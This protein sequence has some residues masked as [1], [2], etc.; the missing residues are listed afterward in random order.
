MTA[1]R[2]RERA[3][4]PSPPERLPPRRGGGSSPCTY[5]VSAAGRPAAFVR[6]AGARRSLFYSARALA[7]AALLAVLCA[8]TLP[9]TAQA[10]VLVSNLGQPG[11]SSSELDDLDS[12]FLRA[13]AFSVPA[14]GGDYSLASSEI[15]IGRGIASSNF[16]SLSVSVW[17]ADSSGHP[18]S[19]LY[20]L[21]NPS[22]T[23]SANA[24]GTFRAPAD[25]TL[26]AGQTYLVVVHYAKEQANAPDWQGTESD[27]E[28]VSF[29]T[30]WTIAD[31]GLS[32]RTT[33][34]SWSDNDFAFGI[35]VN[36]T[37][38]P[39][40]APVF[41][42]TTA[43]RTVPENSTVGTA[44][45]APVTATDADTGDTLT[46]SLEGTDAASFDIDSGT[47]QIKT[48]TGVTYNYE[49]TK[50]SYSVTV[51]A[52]DGNSGTDTIT[53]TISVTDVAE[54]PSKP[55]APSLTRVTGS[56]T[57]LS[58]SWS[59]P[60][61]D[62]GPAL[63]GYE[64]QY[65]AG[66]TGT[67]SNSTSHGATVTTATI[68]GLTADTAYQVQVR[69]LN[70]ETPS[71]WSEPSAS[72]RTNALPELSVSNV[73][74]Q[75]GNALTFRVTLSPAS[76]VTVTVRAAT[77]VEGSAT[78]EASDF[79]A[80]TTT[81]TFAANEMSKQVTVTTREDSTDEDNETF[82]LT[83]SNP[84]NAALS[85]DQTTLAVF[86]V[87]EDDDDPPVLSVAPAAATEGAPVEFTVSLSAVS[88]KTVTVT[89]ATS[90]GGS[91]TAVSD[92]FTTV[93]E[94]LTFA[95][96]DRSKTVTVTTAN[97]RLDEEDEETFTLTLSGPSNAT[98][99][100][101]AST[102]VGTIRD[103]DDR[104][105]ITI[106]AATVNEGDGEIE[107]PLTL[108]RASGREVSAVWY[109]DTDGS[110]TAEPDDIVGNLSEF[111]ANRK[112]VFPPGSVSEQIRITLFDDTTDEPDE[113]FLVQLAGRVNAT[114][115]S[116]SNTVTIEDNDDPP[117][118]SIA[119]DVEQ[120]ESVA[121][122]RLTVNLSEAS[123]KE[124][125]F[126]LRR[127]DRTSDTA[128]A[129]D[130]STPGE[131][132]NFTIAA[133]A[134]SVVASRA[135]IRNDTTDEPD[136][137]FTLEIHDFRN[138]TGGTKTEA[139]VTIEDDDDPP[140]VSVAN[141]SAEEGEGAEFMVR[142]SAESGKTVT[143][144]VAT[145]GGGS[146]TA[147]SGSDYWP[148][149]SAGSSRT[150][151]PGTTELT[152]RVGLIDDTIDEPDEIFTLTLSDPSNATLS[153]TNAT[154]KGTIVDGDPAPTVTLVLTPSSIDEDG[155]TTRTTVTA[156]LTN[157]STQ[158][159]T[160]TVSAAAVSPAVAG[161]FALSSNRT[162]A[163]AA[164]ETTSTGT[165][166]IAANDNDVDAPD[167]RVTV[168][169]TAANT[170][171]V[172]GD[173]AGV[174]LTIVDDEATPTVTLSLSSSSI[175]ENGG[176][177]V[178]TAS[179]T[180]RSSEATTVTLT[181]AP[182]DWTADGGGVLAI[183]AGE[184]QS[185]GS[186]TL[187]AV[188]DQTDA[189]DKALTVTASAVN[190]Q[191]V[192]QPAGVALEITDDEA[193]PTATLTV[194]A[195]MI[196]EDGGTATVSVNLDHA[197][198]EPTTV[199]VTAAGADP[200]AAAFTLTGATLTVPAGQTAGSSTA[201][202][203]AT[204]NEVDAPDQTVTV[205]AT[206]VNTQGIAGDPDDVTL[207]I[208]DDE[209]S[210]GVTL[211][212]SETSIGEAGGVATVTA[213]L[214]HPSSEATTVTVTAAAVSPAE[215]GD[216]TLSGS[217]LTIPAMETDSTGTVTVTGVD[218]DVD[219]ADKRVTVSA[220]AE[221]T[222]GLAGDPP[223]LTL[224]IEDDDERGLAFLPAAL[225]L[226]ESEVAQNAYTVALTSEPTA[227]VTLT[228][229]SPGVT[230]LGV[231][232]SS[233]S[234]V[235]VSWTLTFT[236]D[237]WNDPQA[238]SL[239]AGSDAD[240]APATVRLRHAA[241]GGDYGSVSENYAVTI[242]DTDAPTR[243]IV[244]SVDRS[245]VPEGGGVQ[246]L[247]VTARLDAAPLTGPA[248][249]AVTVG[250]GTAEAGDV[251]PDHRGG[252]VLGLADGDADARGRR[253]R[254]GA[255]DGDGLRHDHDDPG[256]HGDSAGGDR[257]GGDHHGRR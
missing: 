137:T 26:E 81:L 36:G 128:T 206:A 218:N 3:H 74:A 233:L 226:S 55:S 66:S 63:T 39:N 257:G 13:Q 103:N 173:P 191:G 62:G 31:A 98:L 155:G 163:I 71:D 2:A 1:P 118:L 20:S 213:S 151:T 195:S 64:M 247:E 56:A 35:R 133:D 130:L 96:G 91:D 9:A 111:D 204:D 29:A 248:S 157:P 159:T 148:I 205:M 73:S 129:A 131:T 69:A 104:P 167:K 58:A 194:T 105:R 227:T 203:T 150:F 170:Q 61:L 99:S 17:S 119:A 236:P 201:T 158:A 156:T 220:E 97:D 188:N 253:P 175:G 94:T 109:V 30:G 186:V 254:R 144:M 40:T 87:I 182:G 78:A 216:F 124:V 125:R 57:S 189:P 90:I 42:G 50:N 95:P 152:V 168:S 106:G 126:K 166:T 75:E 101:T 23:I 165:V 219:A 4:P 43:T 45:G 22:S 11:I 59:A 230:A 107:V 231:S 12:D 160:V 255:R 209:G 33:E 239:V 221:N 27:D 146:D 251:Q 68:T 192:E 70:G 153:T 7:A 256:R 46:Y 83:L 136:E 245:E 80:V 149:G 47:G 250:P 113:T 5:A 49:A 60:D 16:G 102:A 183:A 197:S 196:S 215:A 217:V 48:K 162:L 115:A 24:L 110:Y 123:E 135:Y 241:S 140:T 187:T 51:K 86:G 6:L 28:D 54:Q 72:V 185:S 84:T 120:L 210:P 147:E 93:S 208:P 38:P 65:R 108:N 238:L 176:T 181:A 8:L 100:T 76:A 14:G 142:L 223:P 79:T 249:V 92:D 139:T 52:D 132:Q 53:V 174:T 172:D 214:S 244:L 237:D 235:L 243:N 190:T 180:G 77:S 225:T 134:T 114:F 154:A 21:T 211:A 122:V 222:Q 164:G 143:V 212:L 207:T 37:P 161:D 18:D 202:L 19:S 34:T 169:A 145:P 242:A 224:I 177:T 82:T 228:V 199:T 178:A 171:G 121:N 141:A 229:T 117:T 234:P 25:A 10:D 85:N 112:V 32:R 232:D 88:G 138:A 193:A 200:K 41:S 15:R 179:L 198:S 246:P 252:R 44:V 127:V 240:S 89:A 67:W 184:T 116:S